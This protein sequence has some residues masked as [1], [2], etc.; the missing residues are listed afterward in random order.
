MD[1]L[2]SGHTQLIEQQ[3]Y[4]WAR[5]YC[6]HYGLVFTVK[7]EGFLE[8]YN[9]KCLIQGGDVFLFPPALKCNFT[10]GKNWEM[11]WFHFLPRQDISP[12]LGWAVKEN[13]INHVR[14]KG[15]A[16]DH[17]LASLKEAQ[18][19]EL[20]R[21]KGWYD[22][23]IRLIETVIVRAE[24][25]AMLDKDMD[26]ESFL[27]AQ[28][29]LVQ[30]SAKTVNMEDIAR[31]CGVSRTKL[32]Y[33]FQNKTGT[34]PQK[35]RENYI[36]RKAQRMLECTNLQICEISLKLGISD[37]Y[38][39]SARFKKLCGLSPKNYR[40]AFFDSNLTL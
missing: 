31:E 28:K 20:N 6:K 29:L 4:S 25:I 27:K 40:K 26:Y 22:L 3:G 14:L 33:L 16:Y 24:N 10:A 38:Y 8:A 11:Y 9:E 5:R 15:C 34:T 18:E 17:V 12:N 30:D 21:C 13:E 19:L 1:D 37:P 2:I 36:M 32:Y 39:F 23:A 35:F 7:G